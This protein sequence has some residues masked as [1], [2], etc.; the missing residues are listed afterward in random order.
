MTPLPESLSRSWQ[1]AAL[2]SELKS[3]PL[4]RTIADTPLA[5]FRDAD[6]RAAALIDR[7]PHRNY[8][9][10]EGRVV[11]GAV[12]CPYHGWRF[13]ADGACVEVAGCDLGQGEG[14]RLSAAAVE[15]KEIN[16]AVFVRLKS[17]GSDLPDL[18]V[19]DAA[20]HDHFWWEQGL[21]R[22]RTLDALENVMDPFHTNH[23]HDGVIRRSTR[24]MPV[25]MSIRAGETWLESIIRQPQPD[26][27]WMSRLLEPPRERSVTRLHAPNIIQARWEGP[28]GLTLLVT[29]LFTPV[30]ATTLRLFARFTTPKGR[31]PGWLKQ[32]AIRLFMER[33]VTQ[34]KHALATQLDNIERF[35]APRFLQGPGD[36]PGARVAMLYQG[37]TL[38]PAEEG[39]FDCRL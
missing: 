35:G 1:I 7:C 3:R 25:T 5:L 13:G 19:W 21:W 14:L 34:D 23:V 31:G 18:G 38:E 11:E 9:L 27:G 12:Q 15:A 6:G 30:S 4:A 32:A 29:V 22:G 2:S 39:P 33:V 8:P 26:L 24:R 36:F 20:D 10:S 17:G 16:G 37:Q 28:K